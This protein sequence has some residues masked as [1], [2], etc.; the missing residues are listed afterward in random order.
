MNKV[1][2]RGYKPYKKVSGVYRIWSLVHPDRCYVGSSDHIYRRWIHHINFLHNGE[3][4]SPHLQNHYNKYGLNDLVFE[5]VAMCS[6]EDL[7]AL[8]KIIWVEQSF[9]Y[10]YKYK[11]TQK[12]FF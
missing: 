3:H 9:F 12:P 1:W 6:V 4:H 5:I 8:D 10:A 7:V 11:N 2:N